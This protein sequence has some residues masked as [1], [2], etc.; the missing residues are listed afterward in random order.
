MRRWPRPGLRGEQSNTFMGELW[1]VLDPLFQAAIY[2]FLVTVIRGGRGGPDVWST[3]TLIIVGR[4]PVQLHTRRARRRWP[5]DP[6]RAR[7]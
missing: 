1:G 7:A 2:M 4:V 6:Q 3:A 5:V